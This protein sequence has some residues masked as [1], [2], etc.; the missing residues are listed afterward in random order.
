MH[1]RGVHLIF[2]EGLEDSVSF[3]FAQANTLDIFSR[4]S[5]A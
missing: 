3:F 1:L 4:K 5:A 2:E